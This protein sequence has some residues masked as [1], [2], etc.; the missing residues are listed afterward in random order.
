VD[1]YVFEIVH[2]VIGLVCTYLLMIN[3]ALESIDI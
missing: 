3:V 1:P 2:L